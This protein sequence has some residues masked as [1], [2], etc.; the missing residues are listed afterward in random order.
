MIRESKGILMKKKKN[1]NL[2][3][4]IIISSILTIILLVGMFYTPY[5]PNGMNASSKFLSPDF[6]HFMGT[7]NF[8]RDIF[9]RVMVGLGTTFV[10][11]FSTV[12]IGAFF[13]M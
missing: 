1:L 7:D 9:S 6:N 12:I 4:G 3:L 2:I 10:V 11:A 8:G 5:D 13:G